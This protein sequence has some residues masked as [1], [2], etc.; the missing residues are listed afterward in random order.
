VIDDDVR[1]PPSVREKLLP[2]MREQ[3]AGRATANRP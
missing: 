2:Q 3:L 1:L